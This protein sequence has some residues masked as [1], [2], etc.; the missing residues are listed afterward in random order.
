MGKIELGLII[1][2]SVII[3]PS[4]LN[5][6]LLIVDFM[7]SYK[8]DYRKNYPNIDYITA[9]DIICYIANEHTNLFA[10]AVCPVYS[11]FCLL[12]LMIKIACFYI[13][14]AFC[15]IVNP[16]INAEIHIGK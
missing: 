7:I 3:V 13:W 5:M 14:K 4:L 10:L 16:L 11:S 1:A 2:L 6:V 15:F 9:N 12:Y 8:K